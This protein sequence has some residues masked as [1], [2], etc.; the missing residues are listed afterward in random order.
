MTLAMLRNRLY[1]E[2]PDVG[3]GSPP[4]PGAV[5]GDSGTPPAEPAGAENTVTPGGSDPG[6]VPYSRFKEV[7]EARR[8][9][10]ESYRPYADLEQIGYGADDFQRL[11]AWET[12]FM[13]DPVATWMNQ[14]ASIEGLPQSV[15]DAIAA[16]KAEAPK[17][18]PS[19]ADAGP[20]TPTEPSDQ[21]PGTEPPE[22]AKPLL[23]DH[24]Q[25]T[26]AQQ[27]SAEDAVLN[28]ITNAWNTIDEGQGIITPP[29]MM[30]RY[31]QD[32]Q[33]Q[34]AEAILTDARERFLADR[35]VLLKAEIKQ[36][37]NGSTVPRAVPGS[38]GTTPATEPVRPTSLR[39]AT[40]LALAAHERG[41]L[42]PTE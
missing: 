20:P 22:W 19:D 28:A 27:R 23:Q 26:E 2:A 39:D 31:L 33:G 18:N 6:P 10:E 3:G 4:V 30:L 24:Q 37:G 1:F 25:R 13:Q 21:T 9:L 41:Q 11:A 8:T 16:S 7:N 14:A 36:P 35:E 5:E 15:K 34:T 12:E 40:K 17:G 32:A 42:V 29:S 38:G